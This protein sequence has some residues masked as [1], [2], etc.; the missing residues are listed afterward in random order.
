MFVLGGPQ[1]VWE[2]DKYP[3]LRMEKQAIR[4]WV[5][6]RAKPYFGVCLGHQLLADALG[7]EVALSQAGE[8]GIMSVEI[9]E[10]GNPLAAG[11]AGGHKVVQWHMAE[12]VKSPPTAEVLGH[13]E[14][15]PMQVLAIGEHALSTQFHSEC[16]AQSLMAWRN[17]PGYIDI[18]EAHKGKGSYDRFLREAY[19]AI[20]EINATS[21][22]L[23]VNLLSA[24]N[25]V[26]AGRTMRF[27]NVVG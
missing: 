8:H 3:W 11:L 1:D 20:G 13:S 12:V 26:S 6:D 4:E 15:S 14:L 21:E 17:T 22:R 10:N 23:Y 7:G 24:T 19:S 18:F 27:R 5:S 9:T 2:E 16:G 25:L